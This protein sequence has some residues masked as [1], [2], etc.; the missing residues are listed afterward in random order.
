MIE[1]KVEGMTCGH[2]EQAVRR[3]LAA[4]P[5][6]ITVREVDRVKQYASVEGDSDPAALIAA[7]TAEGYRACIA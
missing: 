2:C 3:A 6:V 1:L 5:G 7:I 4:V